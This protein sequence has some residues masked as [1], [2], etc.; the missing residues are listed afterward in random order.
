M[1]LT[2]RNYG[3]LLPKNYVSIEKDEMEYID[4][5]QVIKWISPSDCNRIA[6]LLTLE[7]C[8]LLAK[9][10]II[11]L[12]VSLCMT[13]VAGI[14]SAAVTSLISAMAGGAAAYFWLAS[15]FNGMNFNYTFW[16]YS[17]TIAF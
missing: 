1:T 6:A 5:G 17:F 16:T 2:M 12:V 11:T 10:A 14:I 9:G 4:G 7:A 3:L 15:T 8:G 13:P